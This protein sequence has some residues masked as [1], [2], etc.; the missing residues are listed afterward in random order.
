LGVPELIVLS[1]IGLIV[2]K[3][4]VSDMSDQNFRGFCWQFGQEYRW[5]AD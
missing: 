3:L 4:G 5:D 2:I 1:Q